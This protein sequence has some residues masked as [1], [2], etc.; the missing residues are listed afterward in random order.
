MRPII[1]VVT[2]AAVAVA[3]IGLVETAAAQECALTRT[4][5]PRRATPPPPPPPPPPAPRASRCDKIWKA[6]DRAENYY[7][8]R[9]FVWNCPGSRHVSTAERRMV[10]LKPPPPPPSP[11]PAPQS[12][13]N[14]GDFTK[15]WRMF[16]EYNPGATYAGDAYYAARLGKMLR[17]Y[18]FQRNTRHAS[19]RMG[20]MLH[21]YD[22]VEMQAST[23]LTMGFIV[24][25]GV[26]NGSLWLFSSRSN[27]DKFFANP[28]LYMPRFGGYCTSC[29][30]EGRFSA[31]SQKFT[32]TGPYSGGFYIDAFPQDAAGKIQPYDVVKM[33]SLV[34]SANSVWNRYPNAILPLAPQT[35]L[36][37]QISAAYD[38][39]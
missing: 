17:Q 24:H 2:I 8:Y 16:P 3:A 34:T 19:D 11:P 26:Y 39:R 13:I 6:A 18:G 25:S 21:G 37:L 23:K 38:A 15:S 28:S 35:P 7:T 20:L 22:P 32:L 1:V 29:L 14:L 10:I 12:V 30:A 9:D 27:L 33:N 31:P 4:C 5:P 36:S